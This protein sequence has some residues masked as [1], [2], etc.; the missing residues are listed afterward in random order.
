MRFWEILRGY[1][2]LALEITDKWTWFR[3][4]VRGC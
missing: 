2:P 1:F 3:P 4:Q